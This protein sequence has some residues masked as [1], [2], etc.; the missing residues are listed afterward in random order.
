MRVLRKK[1]IKI[2]ESVGEEFSTNEIST[3]GISM[4][5]IPT[6]ELAYLALTSKIE[7]PI[8]NKWAYLLHKK[9]GEDFVV[10]R[11]WRRADLAILESVPVSKK[12]K[13]LVPR[14][15][16]ELKAMYTFEGLPKENKNTKEDPSKIMEDLRKYF[17]YMTED[18]RK[19]KVLAATALAEKCKALKANARDGSV[20]IK[21]ETDDEK[22]T[23]KDERWEEKQNALVK[24]YETCIKKS[25]RPDIYTVL[26]AT[27]PSLS[28]DD[29]KYH[30]KKEG[31]DPVIKYSPAVRGESKRK[32]EA[33]ERKGDYK[34][35]VSKN[36]KIMCK[37][38]FKDEM[39]FV[40]E[41][42]FEGGEAFGI[43]TDVLYWIFKARWKEDCTSTATRV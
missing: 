21:W 12:T 29:D 8:R 3:N 41:G 31:Y 40:N 19:S 33:A 34:D 28:G 25:E 35:D 39:G 30:E 16:I 13:I 27:R 36:V 26:L 42:K 9:L 10:S 24:K 1:L 17:V 14:C 7:I 15:L 18:I 2:L 43:K 38:E 20:D 11:E 22:V 23:K 37:K 4:K 32:M 6:N 5:E